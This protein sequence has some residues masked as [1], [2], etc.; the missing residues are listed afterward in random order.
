MGTALLYYTNNCVQKTDYRQPIGYTN[1]LLTTTK[2]VS[3]YTA[4]LFLLYLILVTY[5]MILRHVTISFWNM[6]KILCMC[7]YYQLQ[8]ESK[9]W[10]ESITKDMHKINLNSIDRYCS[11]YQGIKETTWTIYRYLGTFINTFVICFFFI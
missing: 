1:Y 4:E 7:L 6:L 2:L 11:Y 9:K 3:T 10:A 5:S 8:I